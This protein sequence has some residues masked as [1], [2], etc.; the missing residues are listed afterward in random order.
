MIRKILDACAL[1]GLLVSASLAG[2]SFYLYKYVTSPSFEKEVK[3]K[4]MKEV[5]SGIPLPSISGPALPTGA[6][7]PKQQKNEEKKAFGLPSF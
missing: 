6:L 7:S 1:L 2:G 3:D 5:T 4:I